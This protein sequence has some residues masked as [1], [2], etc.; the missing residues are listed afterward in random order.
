MKKELFNYEKIT[1]LLLNAEKGKFYEGGL[2]NYVFAGAI[3]RDLINLKK[4]QIEKQKKHNVLELIDNSTTKDEILDQCLEKIDESGKIKKLGYWISKLSNCKKIKKRI[5]NGMHNKGLLEKN[6]KT[7]LFFFKQT[8]YSVTKTH[9]PIELKE[10]IKYKLMDELR[11]DYETV[12]FISLINC[13]NL[14]KQVIGKEDEKRYRK[15]IKAL[16]KDNEIGIEVKKIIDGV[17]AAILIAA[18]MPAITSATR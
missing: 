4:I 16:A 18:I 2:I 6:E 13:L 7:V 11:D 17:R 1:L 14:M 9:I 3:I 8:Y 10:K 5:L 15:K 12:F